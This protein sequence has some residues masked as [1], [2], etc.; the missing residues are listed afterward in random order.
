[1]HRFEKEFTCL[2][3]DGNA[4][5]RRP[6]CRYKVSQLDP[7]EA[8]PSWNLSQSKINSNFHGMKLYFV[9][10]NPRKPTNQSI[11]WFN[12]WMKISQMHRNGT[13]NLFP[14][15]Y[16]HVNSWNEMNYMMISGSFLWFGVVVWFGAKTQTDFPRRS[17][18]QTTHYFQN[19]VKRFMIIC[20]GYH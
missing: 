2:T 6:E 20:F 3:G 19:V 17:S 7:R 12:I 4:Q 16:Y 14:K 10:N 11:E 15:M 9:W 13:R 18:M 1:M 5:H 8:I